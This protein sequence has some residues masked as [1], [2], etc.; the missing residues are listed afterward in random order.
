MENYLFELT[1]EEKIE[2][3]LRKNTN[4]F[5]LKDKYD[6][7]GELL[8]NLKKIDRTPLDVQKRSCV[9]NLYAMAE[10]NICDIRNMK[11]FLDS[12]TDTDINNYTKKHPEWLEY[13]LKRVIEHL[14]I[15]VL[16]VDKI[17]YECQN[18]IYDLFDNVYEAKKLYLTQ[19]EILDICEL[20]QLTNI[21][22]EEIR[23]IDNRNL[24]INFSELTNDESA[25]RYAIQEWQQK[26]EHSCECLR[27]YIL[28][29]IGARIPDEFLYTYNQT[30]DIESF[31]LETISDNNSNTA[32]IEKCIQTFDKEQY[33]DYLKEHP[34]DYL[35][36]L[37][38][39]GTYK[40][41]QDYKDKIN[42]AK[43]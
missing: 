1:V 26:A 32:Y 6:K 20:Y 2:S 34:V 10:F 8:K 13:T 40:E 19:K 25:K 11:Y 3:E 43:V 15:I 29:F 33:I 21:I 27:H 36:Y 14:K 4:Y 18:K 30:L 39:L 22:E 31:F 9:D 28:N 41:Y 38:E 7:L 17:C 35:E 5:T 23:K 42:Q 24:N 16:T 12:I 37:K